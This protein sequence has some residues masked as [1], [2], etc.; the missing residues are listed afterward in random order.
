MS[1]K[2]ACT[3]CR[4]TGQHGARWILRI[5]NDPGMLV[6]KPC[7]QRL[8]AEAPNGVQVKLYPTR[9]L[10][11]EFRAQNFWK[12]QFREAEARTARK[13]EA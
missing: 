5:G 3:F 8:I 2:K 10:A 9:D 7:G 6:H 4:T 12:E 13:Q 1:E 11:D